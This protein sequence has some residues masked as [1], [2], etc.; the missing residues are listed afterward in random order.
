[1]QVSQWL[2]SLW[3]WSLK[4]YDYRTLDIIMHCILLFFC[5]KITEYKIFFLMV[6]KC[7]Y[8]KLYTYLLPMLHLS[9]NKKC[10]YFIF[11]FQCV[12]DCV[13][14]YYLTKKN[15]NYKTLVRRN[16]GRRRGRNQVSQQ[17]KKN[18]YFCSWKIYWWRWI[19]ETARSRP[20][21]E[22]DWYHRPDHTKKYKEVFV[23]KLPCHLAVRCNRFTCWAF[24]QVSDSWHTCFIRLKGHFACDRCVTASYSVSHMVG[25]IGLCFATGLS[26]YSYMSVS[27]LEYTWP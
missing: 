2:E 26:G 5:W 4:S 15:H 7:V 18:Q 6:H 14:Y 19:N 8:Y 23:W 21:S 20:I 24:S 16:L 9:N 22:H 3:M 27:G 12:A 25:N 1:M 13:L 11:W 17:I 10:K